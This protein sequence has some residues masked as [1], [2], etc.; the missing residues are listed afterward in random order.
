MSSKREL[1]RQLRA[2]AGFEEPSP[3]LEQY[4][5][6][7]DIAATLVHTAALQGD[8]TDRRVV[9]L[10]CGTGMLALAS[11]LYDPASVVGM[12]VDLAALEIARANARELDIDSP[13]SW[14]HGD[15]SR[16]PLCASERPIT[17]LMNPPFGAQAGN[18]HADRPFLAAAALAD[19]SYSIHN[20]GSRE[21]VEAYASERAGEVTHAF[22]AEFDLER[23]FEF[24]T[25]ESRTIDVEVF[26]IDW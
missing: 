13:V 24:H 5:T 17:V 6:P 18:E 2:V 14:V 3:S 12:D 22:G 7:P 21:F 26:R 4:A 15:V 16:H 11:A 8:V 1:A 19:V 25:E 10:G 9:D 23:S 20:A